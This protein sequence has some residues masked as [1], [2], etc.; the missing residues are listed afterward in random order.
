MG[1]AMKAGFGLVAVMAAI[2]FAGPAF[3]QKQGSISDK[4]VTTLVNYAWRAVPPQVTLRSGK[5]VKFDRAK[6][7]E[8][9]LPPE[10]AKEII[11]AA[12]RSYE[13]QIC[14]L[15]AAVIANR[16]AMMVRF[17]KK[18]KWSEQQEQYAN[19]L[20]AFVV[21]YMSGKVELRYIDE[22]K[23]DV[24]VSE[25]APEKVV[26]PKK[27]AP[28]QKKSVDQRIYDYYTSTPGMKA[29]AAPAAGK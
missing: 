25:I 12:Y 20:H 29:R 21:S 3:A 27:C 16:D 2:V 28:D 15:P 9:E 13:A 14:E 6:R 22:N 24:K 8:I 17:K 5:V 10:T 4:T 19:L 23:T 18:G 26:P 11:I 7:K 1:K